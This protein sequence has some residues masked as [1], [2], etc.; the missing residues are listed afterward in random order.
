MIVVYPDEI[1]VSG[2]VGDHLGEAPVDRVVGV[3]EPRLEVAL[4]LEV[5]E[6]RPDHLIGEPQVEVVDLLALGVDAS[7]RVRLR[8]PGFGEY[9]VDRFAVGAGPTRPT[10][11]DPTPLTQNRIQGRDQ[12]SG[13]GRE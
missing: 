11:P 6:Q 13:P 1:V 10:D 5:V 3:P 9:A 7:Q 8:G 4:A 12:P 2:L